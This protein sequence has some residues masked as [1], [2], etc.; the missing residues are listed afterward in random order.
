M[1]LIYRLRESK[2]TAEENTAIFKKLLN[3]SLLGA[4]ANIHIT[5]AF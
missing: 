3:S 1:T 4:D 2:I 5:K